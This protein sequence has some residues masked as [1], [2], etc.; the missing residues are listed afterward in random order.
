MICTPAEAPFSQN[1]ASQTPTKVGEL[2]R[3]SKRSGHRVTGLL[4]EAEPLLKLGGRQCL[5]ALV[6]LN[7]VDQ[8]LLDVR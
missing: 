7:D 2:L 1:E 6:G 5:L 4:Y 8:F 3:E